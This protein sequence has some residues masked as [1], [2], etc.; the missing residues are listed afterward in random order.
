MK[1]GIFTLSVVLLAAHAAN[2]FP[3]FTPRWQTPD[4][5]M[6]LNWPLRNK[7]DEMRAKEMLTGFQKAEETADR[8]ASFPDFFAQQVNNWADKQLQ[9]AETTLG[10]ITEQA[11]PLIGE[12]NKVVKQTLDQAAARLEQIM[13]QGL[14]LIDILE[15]GS[16]LLENAVEETLERI[17]EEIFVAAVEEEEELEEEEFD[18]ELHEE[19]DEIEDELLVAAVEEG[20][21]R[22]E[23]EEMVVDEEGEVE[24]QEEEIVGEA[25]E[26]KLEEPEETE[27]LEDIEEAEVELKEPESEEPALEIEEP[28]SEEPESIEPF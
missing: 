23:V 17:N 13:K 4:S 8:I 12:A 16:Q 27:E 11:Q 2:A 26:E 18:E 22:T 5:G 19:E 9:T 14:Y 21:E 25:I 24:E 10:A 6:E 7:V 28:E 15:A 1:I 3:A 20:E